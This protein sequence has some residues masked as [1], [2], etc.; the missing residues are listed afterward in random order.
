MLLEAMEDLI[1]PIVEKFELPTLKANPTAAAALQTSAVMIG[2]VSQLRGNI[3]PPQTIVCPPR[4]LYGHTLSMPDRYLLYE[5][6]QYT[7]SYNYC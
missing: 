4:P 2:V 5:N 3:C 1:D 6:L 7:L